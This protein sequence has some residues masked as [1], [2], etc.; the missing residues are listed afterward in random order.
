M[1]AKIGPLEKEN[2]DLLAGGGRDVNLNL[3]LN[4][5]ENFSIFKLSEFDY[6]ENLSRNGL[7]KWAEYVKMIVTEINSDFINEIEKLQS[8]NE[9][10]ESYLE[11]NNIPLPEENSVNLQSPN[12]NILPHPLPSMTYED[13]LNYEPTKQQLREYID[14]IF[15]EWR[16]DD[17]EFNNQFNITNKDE[18]LFQELA[19]I[20][21]LNQL[22]A[23]TDEEKKED[24]NNKENDEKKEDDVENNKENNDENNENGSGNKGG[25]DD[26]QND[27][28]KKLLD[29]IKELEARIKELTRYFSLYLSYSLKL[30]SVTNVHK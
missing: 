29:K 7:K 13:L 20:N 12:V 24:E 5:E 6:P 25:S 16:N 2:Q 28:E 22:N 11:S 27:K 18:K 15:K 21:D 14:L 19:K 17:D 10:Y 4:L 9:M 3:K 1:K 26:K 30:K 8:K 23:K